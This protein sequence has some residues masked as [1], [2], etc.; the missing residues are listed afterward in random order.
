MNMK[1]AIL[2]LI[3]EYGSV[4]FAELHNLEGFAGDGVMR[5][6]GNPHAV[7]WA[8]ISELAIDSLNELGQKGLIKYSSD[9]LTF[10]CYAWDGKVVPLPMGQ[11]D[12]I[13]KYK[14]RPLDTNY[15]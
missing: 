12:K 7:L 11:I 10:H 8:D 15:G 14:K 3:D 1:E 2:D 4:T 5:F 13:S 6:D 9:A